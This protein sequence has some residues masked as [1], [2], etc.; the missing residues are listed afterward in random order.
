MSTVGTTA[1][2]SLLSLHTYVSS[3][4]AGSF[5]R[6]LERLP[7]ERAEALRG[8]IMP[9]R[10]Y[11][12]ASLLAAFEAAYAEFGPAFPEEYGVWAARYAIHSFFRFLLKF[13]TPNWVIG[14]A[15]RMWRSYHDTGEWDVEMAGNHFR[16]TL[17][18]FCGVSAIYCRYLRAWFETAGRM[19][20]ATN[21]DLQHPECRASGADACVFV[22]SW[23]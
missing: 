2:T 12:T 9:N 3:L 23:D 6:I 19:T 22:G 17:R 13:K 18:D 7:P 16:G 1:G 5:D 4:R 14:R 10:R 11:P 8:I 21:I 15:M 20:G